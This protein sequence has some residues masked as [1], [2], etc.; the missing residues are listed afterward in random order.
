MSGTF[1]CPNFCFF[2]FVFFVTCL[3]RVAKPLT[4]CLHQLLNVACVALCRSTSS[5][6]GVS[7]RLTS[8]TSN[9]CSSLVSCFSM[10]S[11][12]SSSSSMMSLPSSFSCGFDGC[13]FGL[14]G[15]GICNSV[16]SRGPSLLGPSAVA[17]LLPAS[18]PLTPFVEHEFNG[19]ALQ[20]LGVLAIVQV[21]L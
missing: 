19:L 10:S 8:G 16:A 14:I 1:A 3:S 4:Q 6:V 17:S 12:L 15:S 13:R 7:G 21:L 2:P 20:N 9:S 18:R 11:I 5:F